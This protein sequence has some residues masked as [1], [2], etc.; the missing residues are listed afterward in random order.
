[1]Q[2]KLQNTPPGLNFRLSEG[3][4]GAESRQVQPPSATDPI[5]GAE[6]G[7]VLGRLPAIK[8]D[9]DDQTEFAKRIG[10]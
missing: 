7:K 6:A 9:P 3:A 10:T 4:A 1:M 2:Q 8:S 5:S